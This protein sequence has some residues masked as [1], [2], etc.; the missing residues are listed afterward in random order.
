M[1]LDQTPSVPSQGR[2]TWRV[3]GTLLLVVA[4]GFV[5]LAACVRAFVGSTPARTLEV[6]RSE[7]AV[8]VPKFYPLPS[9]GADAAG[10][11]FGVW[12]TLED[13]RSATAL[14][15]RDPYSGCGVPWRAE[16]RVAEVTGV[17]RDPCRGAAY[18][19]DG[20][21]IDGTTPRGL[22]SYDVEVTAGRLIIDL[23]RV[24]VGMCPS[25][26]G[27]GV[28]DCSRPGAPVYRSRPLAPQLT[29]GG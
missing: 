12:V 17:F 3:L 4:I 8:R 28:S 29:P 19:R 13:D 11:T 18:D 22:D 9:M 1:A 15:A 21:A 27:T 10:R 25:G 7:L 24:R 5:G 20:T 16:L 6:L 14:L 2:S 23:T 26:G